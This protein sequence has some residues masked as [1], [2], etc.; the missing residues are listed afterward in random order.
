MTEE[1]IQRLANLDVGD[2]V[3]VDFQKFTGP[4][5]LEPATISGEV[6]ERRKTYETID[7]VIVQDDDGEEYRIRSRGSVDRLRDSPL[8]KGLGRH[9]EITVEREVVA[10]GGRVKDDGGVEQKLRESYMDIAV[11]TNGADDVYL[12]V[13]DDIVHLDRMEA[14]AVVDLLSGK[15]Q[16]VNGDV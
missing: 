16:E 4:S 5:D 11:A 7:R 1:T 14:D 12:K 13:Y 9:A 10:D 15:L 2:N 8:D 6:T 3:V